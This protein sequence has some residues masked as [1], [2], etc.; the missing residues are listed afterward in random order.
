VERVRAVDRIG[1]WREAAGRHCSAGFRSLTPRIKDATKRDSSCNSQGTFTV[2]IVAEH[3][4]LSGIRTIVAYAITL[5][6]PHRRG[7]RRGCRSVPT[8]AVGNTWFFVL[9]VLAFMLIGAPNAADHWERLD[10][11]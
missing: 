11:P 7:R 5:A 6:A 2:W 10:D 1:R 9:N 4:G 8:Y 3:I